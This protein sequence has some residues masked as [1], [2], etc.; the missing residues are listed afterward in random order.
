MEEILSADNQKI[1]LAAGLSQHK[2]RL[3]TGLFLAEG[4]RLSEMAAASGWEISFALFTERCLGTER[5]QALAGRLEGKCPLYMVGEKHYRKAA[6]TENPQGVLLVIKQKKMSLA[7]LQPVGQPCYILLDRVQDP[8]NAGT[9][10]RTADAIGASGVFLSRGA[11]DV[12][13]EKVVRS[14]MGSLFHVPVCQGV[15]AEAAA[16]FA[17]K[18]GCRI[19][20]T[21]LDEGARPHFACPLDEPALLI[22]GNEGE[23]V[24]EEFLKLGETMYIPMTGRAESLNVGVSAAVVLYELLRQRQF[25]KVR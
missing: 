12:F 23:G 21:A 5:G 3:K 10:I 16:A 4:V 15:T 11:V 20:V 13:S 22:F 2:Q 19:W 1:K 17:R 8:G 25:S 6:G 9:V 24:S 7:D 18:Q 14:T